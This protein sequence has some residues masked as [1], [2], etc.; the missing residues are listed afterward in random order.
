ML[1]NTQVARLDTGKAEKGGGGRQKENSSQAASGLCKYFVIDDSFTQEFRGQDGEI[2][3]HYTAHQNR[4]TTGC[5]ICHGLLYLYKH[6]NLAAFNPA[7]IKEMLRP[8]AIA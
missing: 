3:V 4:K 5:P 7:M 2:R 6:E 8:L 1:A